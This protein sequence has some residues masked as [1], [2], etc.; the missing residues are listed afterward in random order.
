MQLQGTMAPHQIIS[1]LQLGGATMALADHN[2]H[3]HIGFQP[4]FDAGPGGPQ[5]ASVLKPKQ[6]PELI[7]RLREIE[8]PDVPG[9]EDSAAPEGQDPG[10]SVRRDGQDAD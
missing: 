3:I 6:W 8:N 9:G 7:D 10:V 5:S 4:M 1:L 2:D